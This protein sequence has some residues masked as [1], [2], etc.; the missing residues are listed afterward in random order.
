M[1]KSV[2]IN[3]LFTIPELTAANSLYTIEYLTPLKYNFSGI[4][5]QGP[6]I[7][8]E[9]TLL[10]CQHT[11]YI[12]HRSLLGKCYRADETFVCPQHIL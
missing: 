3:F 8:D 10:R 1:G 5:F 7:R 11:E 4:C 9:L 6:V 2:G 12:L